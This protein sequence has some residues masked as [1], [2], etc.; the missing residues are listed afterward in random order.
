MSL[1]VSNLSNKYGSKTVLDRLSFEMPKS[2]VYALL[3]NQRRRKDNGDPYDARN[4]GERQWGSAVE[5]TTAGYSDL[6]R[7]A[8]WRKSADF[9]QSIR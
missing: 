3:G 5:R 8:I 6:Q 4:A 2:G 9:T 7:P 1:I